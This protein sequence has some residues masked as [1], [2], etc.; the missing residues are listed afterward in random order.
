M[1]FPLLLIQEDTVLCDNV[2]MPRLPHE[3][4]GLTEMKATG[5]SSTLVKIAFDKSL[6]LPS[7]CKHVMVFS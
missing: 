3:S 7:L 5:V 4:T 6:A 2:N 1:H